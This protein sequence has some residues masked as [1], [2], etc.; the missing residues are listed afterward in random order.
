VSK[1]YVDEILPKDN[2]TVDGSKLSALPT[3]AMPSGSIVQVV[4]TTRTTATS[5]NST[6]FVTTGL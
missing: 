2:A 3:S 4:N 1:I 6:S 5:T